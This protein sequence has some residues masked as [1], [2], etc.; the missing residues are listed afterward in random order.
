MLSFSGEDV[1]Q[2]RRLFFL[3]FLLGQQELKNI[4]VVLATL[5]TLLA[6]RVACTYNWCSVAFAYVLLQTSIGNSR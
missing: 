2:L 1:G 4:S 5:E 3:L 6:S